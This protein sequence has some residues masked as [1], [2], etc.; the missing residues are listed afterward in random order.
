MC[1]QS[2]VKAARTGKMQQWLNYRIRVTIQ[3][4]RDIVGQFLAFDRYMNL[5]I[6]DAEEFRRIGGKST[7]GPGQKR[8][9]EKVLKRT[10]GLVL[11]RGENIVSLSIEAGPPPEVRPCFSSTPFFL[12]SLGIGS[13][14]GSLFC[15]HD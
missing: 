10:L 7:G 3:D 13:F 1:F 8:K 6:A 11:L 14:H 15:L 4:R 9:G 5:I 12:L 2:V